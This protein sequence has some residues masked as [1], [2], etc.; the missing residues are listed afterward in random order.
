[1]HMRQGLLRRIVK[2]KSANT[3]AIGAAAIIPL[4]GVIGGGVDASRLYLTKSRL[5]QACDSAVLAARKQ[6]AGNT[7]DGDVSGELEDTADK[8]FAINFPTGMYGSENDSFTL[9]NSEDTRMDGAASVS[10]PTT[11]MQVF[12][13]D[14]VD[15]DVTCSAD[16][17][18]PNIDV[19]MVLDMSGSMAGSR[20]EALKDAVFAFYDEVMAVK[21]DNA[22]VRIGFVPYN[23]SVKVGPMLMA[24]NTDFLTDEWTYQSREY[25]GSSSFGLLPREAVMLGSDNEAH[26][27]WNKNNPRKRDECLA[28]S[29]QTYRIDG[30]D[31][32]ISNVSYDEDYWGDAWPNNQKAACRAT[33]E[34][35]DPAGDYH[36]KPIVM[37]TSAF[38]LG[39]VVGTPTGTKG[40]NRNSQWN[41]C[42]EEAQM[43][44]GNDYT[45]VE[46]DA[47][48]MDID[49]VPDTTEPESQWKPMWPQITFNRGGPA[50]VKTDRNWGT[51][52]G[53]CPT[54]EAIRLTEYPLSGG[55]R[56][57]VFESYVNSL[58]PQGN[59]IHDAGMVWAGRM[60]S[61]DGIFALT[62]ASAPNGD[63]IARHVL[64]M[65]DGAM[66]ANPSRTTLFG[67]YNMDE[68]FA[69]TGPWN[70]NELSATH[71]ARLD[72]VC[73]QIK[74]KNVT[75]W[76]VA[77][78]LPHTSHT[79]GCASGDSRA[80]TAD[81]SDALVEKFRQIASSIAELRI[82]S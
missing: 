75:V 37:D 22:R 8:Y 69:G 70:R 27:H 58:N 42:I 65:T 77:F 64:F 60:I 17:S 32:K 76:S 48:E 7:A 4:I 67:N 73:Q 31:W 61:P 78:G 63:A 74:N 46:A 13:L 62:N 81:N 57:A 20:T 82:T 55:A 2:D 50:E 15:L 30:Y 66:N 25:T 16:L 52:G 39:E 33:V 44:A 53:D 10:V 40:A 49:L 21:P 14:D 9:S 41:G 45:T 43:L 3:L 80:F 11:L 71:S 29:G 5:Q 79:R 59:T 56:D 24:Q 19:I 34:K 38:K 28:Y 1:M 23:S 68:R 47:L 18:L 72:M 36:Y 35:I 26:Y 54:N 12:G 51:H 6:L